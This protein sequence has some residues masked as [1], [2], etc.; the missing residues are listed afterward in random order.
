MVGAVGRGGGAHLAGDLRRLVRDQIKTGKS[1]TE[2]KAYLT[3]RGFAIASEVATTL[4]G[5]LGFREP[6]S[7]SGF[8]V[9]LEL[10]LLDARS[11]P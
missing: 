9:F 6:G 8:T 10:P 3:D 11:E 5:A 4:S 1:D 2:V 7:R